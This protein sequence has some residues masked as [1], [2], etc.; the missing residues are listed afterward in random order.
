MQKIKSARSHEHISTKPF[1]LEMQVVV[2]NGDPAHDAKVTFQ[3]SPEQAG[4]ARLWLVKLPPLKNPDAFPREL[5]AGHW[6]LTLEAVA[7]TQP[8]QILQY[9][10]ASARQWLKDAFYRP[11]PAPTEL[12]ILCLNSSFTI[13]IQQSIN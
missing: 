11:K 12:L 2:T 4:S 9:T 3:F 7:E 5:A 13:T 10:P 6:R 8:L 1:P